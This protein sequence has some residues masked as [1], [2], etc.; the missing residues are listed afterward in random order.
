M[1]Y[2]FGKL[3]VLLLAVAI[4]GIGFIFVW[5]K[6][7]GNLSPSNI[8]ETDPDA[9][10]SASLQEQKVDLYVDYG[11]GKTTSYEGIIIDTKSTV[12][13]I[14]KKKLEQ[15]GSTVTTKSYNLGAMVESING[16]TN[17][18]EYFWAFSVNGQPGSISADKYILKNGD[19]VEWKYTK[20]Q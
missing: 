12:L 7:L 5:A 18:S 16:I 20:I 6:L 1:K 3:K 11:N 10:G 19:V 17:N 4:I 13:S 15:T 2:Y 14:L 8:S 9:T